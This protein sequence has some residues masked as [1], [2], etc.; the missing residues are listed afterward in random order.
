ML[1]SRLHCQTWCMHHVSCPH[2]STLWV[3]YTRLS[4]CTHFGSEWCC[5]SD[6]L[7]SAQTSSILNGDS[8]TLNLFLSADWGPDYA[9]K[10]KWNSQQPNYWSSLLSPFYCFRWFLPWRKFVEIKENGRMSFVL[11]SRCLLSALLESWKFGLSYW[12]F[13]VTDQQA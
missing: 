8:K 13:H 6:P 11:H 10:C 4:Y 9:A 5:S 1:H 2:W 12:P 3:D 7:S